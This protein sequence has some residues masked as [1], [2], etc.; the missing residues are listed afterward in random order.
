MPAT[1]KLLRDLIEMILAT[2]KCYPVQLVIAAGTALNAL[3]GLD[4]E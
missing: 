1:E 4:I 2:P 3:D